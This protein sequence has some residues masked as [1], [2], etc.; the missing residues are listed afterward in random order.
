M[1]KTFQ[2][3]GVNKKFFLFFMFFWWNF[4]QERGFGRVLKIPVFSR[5][6]RNFCRNKCRTGIPVFAPDSSGFLF[7]PKDV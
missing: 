5:F 6:H 7:L 3:V 4:S 2:K 1:G